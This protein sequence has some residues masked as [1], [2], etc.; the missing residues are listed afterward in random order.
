MGITIEDEQLCWEPQVS[1]TQLV[2][3]NPGL[4]RAFLKIHSAETKEERDKVIV[5]FAQEWGPLHLCY[6]HLRPVWHK[7]DRHNLP[8][9]G[10]DF[11]VCP[12]IILADGRCAEPLWGW[13]TYSYLARDV[14]H[15]SV[16]LQPGD[17]TS[18]SNAS[19]TTADMLMVKPERE[20]LVGKV[21]HLIEDGAGFAML[22]TW[23]SDDGGPV[24]RAEVRTL[25]AA[26]GAALWNTLCRSPGATI[27]AKCLKPFPIRQ[28]NQQYCPDCQRERWRV[29]R[30]RARAKR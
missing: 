27:C 6:E 11:P 29:N 1:S 8:H 19:L 23:T 17:S 25:A 26:L 10:P 16:L 12:P 13:L 22:P 18:N 9:G 21:Q 24:W 14:V 15:A 5:R 7:Q 2:T 28:R 30:A 20:E 4:L 3:P